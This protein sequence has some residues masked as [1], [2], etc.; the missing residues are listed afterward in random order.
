MTI[1]LIMI[2]KHHGMNTCY[3]LGVLLT[4]SPIFTTTLKFRYYTFLVEKSKAQEVKDQS[5]SQSNETGLT[6]EG[7]PPW[8]QLPWFFILNTKTLLR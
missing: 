5:L 7:M 6:I 1:D 8:A 2:N 3:V 4:L